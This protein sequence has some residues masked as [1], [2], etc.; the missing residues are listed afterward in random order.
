ME[1]SAYARMHPELLALMKN[2][3]L[4]YEMRDSDPS[5]WLAPQLLAPTKPA[6]LGNWAKAED[7]VL[8]YTYE[9]LPKGMISRLTVRLHRFV[10]DP[11]EAWVTGVL[12]EHGSTSAL[13]EILPSGNEIELRARGPE[14]KAL[15]SVIAA[16]LDALNESFK[17]L[18]DR[19][20]K[21]IPCNCKACSAQATPWFFSQ[22]E[23]VRRKEH[24]RLKVECGRSYDE[25]DVMEL[26]DGI[27]IEKAP[28][29]AR[30]GCGCWGAA[31]GADISGIIC[32]TARRSGRIR[33]VFSQ[34]ERTTD[35]PRDPFADRAL[36]VFSRRNVQ[37]SAAGRIQQED[38]RLR[39]LRMLV[40]YQGR[41]FYIRRI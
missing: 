31:D 16:D 11:E 25:V 1:D 14:H 5:T 2:F 28:A 9:F 7:L 18:R 24:G 37:N 32:R 12:F 15:L 3:E 30:E 10:K 41:Q 29:W 20:D 36:R 27:K 40:L 22:K 13:A 4:C 39:H 35:Q 34:A 38:S 26:L 17:G 23:L 19:V 8:R 21:R 33:C 6:G